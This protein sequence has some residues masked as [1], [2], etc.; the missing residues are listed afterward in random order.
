[1]DQGMKELV[2]DQRAIGA[3]LNFPIPIV[4]TMIPP[5]IGG[6]EDLTLGDPDIQPELN[7]YIDGSELVLR[8]SM[9]LARK[10][11]GSADTIHHVLQGAQNILTSMAEDPSSME[12]DLGRLRTLM[13]WAQYN[14]NVII[15]SETQTMLQLN[16]H[17][18]DRVVMATGEKDPAKHPMIIR[19]IRKSSA[20]TAFTGPFLVPQSTVDDVVS[21][22]QPQQVEPE[23]EQVTVMSDN[24]ESGE[25]CS[26]QV[27]YKE[28]IT[29]DSF[30]EPTCSSGR[31]SRR[32]KNF[33]TDTDTSTH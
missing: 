5:H 8:Q 31:T 30:Q 17:R 27:E 4:S 28:S 32:T 14:N 22:H 7:N 13:N 2:N 25:E 18:V 29:T 6:L 24:E 20:F 19:N 9:W 16:S 15:E 10:S 3:P 26:T 21:S 23:E 33:N 11:L 12:Q 1:M